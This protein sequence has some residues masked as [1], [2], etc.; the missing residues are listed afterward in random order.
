MCATTDDACET[1]RCPADQDRLESW[2]RGLVDIRKVLRM[3]DTPTRF[4]IAP[5][6]W[7]STPTRGHAET[8]G[9]VS[10]WQTHRR[11]GKGIAARLCRQSRVS[12]SLGDRR[13]AVLERI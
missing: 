3:I 2:D 13:R 12:A 6:R 11:E 7:R 8:P 9:I 4:A 1:Q 10:A 5:L